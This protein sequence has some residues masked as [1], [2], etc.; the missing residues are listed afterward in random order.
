MAMM[1]SASI[2][3]ATPAD[4]SVLSDFAR[5]VF[6]ESFGADNTPEDMATYLASAFSPDKQ[7]AELEHPRRVCLLVELDGAIIAYANVR[8]GSVHDAVAAERPAE[9]ER[10][11]VDR[12]WH[13]CGIAAPLMH[14]V[15]TVATEW[16]CDVLWLGVWERN[17]RAIRFY[18]RE[19][20]KRVGAHTFWLGSDLQHDAVM[21]TPL[22]R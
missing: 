13:G 5:R 7:R 11:Y 22:A 9:L 6:D 18:E 1:V 8:D 16:A 14:A 20:F 12:R 19:G 21:A 10:F 4:A 17:P 3:R 2:R 15:R